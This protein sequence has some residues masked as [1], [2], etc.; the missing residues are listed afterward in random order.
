MDVERTIEFI[1]EQQ[2]RNEGAL[3]RIEAGLDKSEAKLARTDALLS[4]AI[5]AGIREA[6]AERRKRREMGSEFDRKMTQ[7]AA[8]QLV[9]E[10]KLQGLIQSLQRGSNG[11]T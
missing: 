5:K 7:L 1:L 9:T 8:A 4:R 2:A 10:E 11:H 6:L 3:A